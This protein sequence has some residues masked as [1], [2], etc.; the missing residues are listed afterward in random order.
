[1]LSR[2]AYGSYV[3]NGQTNLMISV[4]F[5][6]KLIMIRSK[7]TNVPKSDSSC[8]FFNVLGAY[9]DNGANISNNNTFPESM[10]WVQGI[11][12]FAVRISYLSGVKQYGYQN[13]N[14]GATTFTV[15]MSGSSEYATSNYAKP[16]YMC[17]VSGRAYT[18]VAFG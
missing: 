14:V 2:V 9:G 7:I 15:S 12:N 5:S 6:P 18:Y 8:G 1:M 11:E 17:N 16:E 4:G 13:W 10:F 3:G